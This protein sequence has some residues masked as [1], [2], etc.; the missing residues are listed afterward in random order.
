ME[1]LQSAHLLP[2]PTWPVSFQEVLAGV[3][4]W[5]KARSWEGSLE[6]EYLWEPLGMLQTGKEPTAGSMVQGWGRDW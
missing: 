2:Y 4:G 5:T 6:A 3:D 1:D